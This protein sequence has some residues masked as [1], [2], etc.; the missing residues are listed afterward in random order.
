MENTTL[1]IPNITCEHCIMAI[2]NELNDMDGVQLTTG[3]P[4]DKTITVQWN[5]PATLEM[6]RAALKDI[7]YPAE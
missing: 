7:N 5:A 4:E 3:K 6:I 2:K 1:S